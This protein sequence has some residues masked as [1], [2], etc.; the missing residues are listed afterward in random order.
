MIWAKLIIILS[1]YY[2]GK[3]INYLSM[4]CN[5]KI[6]NVNKWL[7]SLKIYIINKL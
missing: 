5:N 6:M 4:S 3:G 1:Y 7:I 2:K